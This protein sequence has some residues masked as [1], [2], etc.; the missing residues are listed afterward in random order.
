MF[1][2]GHFAPR[3]RAIHQRDSPACL[4]S[5][6]PQLAPRQI[7]R[8]RAS[9]CVLEGVGGRALCLALGGGLSSVRRSPSRSTRRLANWLAGWLTDWLTVN[10]MRELNIAPITCHSAPY[11][12]QRR[13]QRA[14]L[15]HMAP[16][17][18]SY[19]L[20]QPRVFPLRPPSRSTVK[21]TRF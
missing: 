17:P 15:L 1:Q 3:L 2:A 13:T 18:A 21:K 19:P 6:R 20:N 16:T 11:G 4:P 7:A 14:R 8:Q 10:D 12:P 9:Y 5:R